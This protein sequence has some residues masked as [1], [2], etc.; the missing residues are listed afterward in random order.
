MKSLFFCILSCAFGFLGSL[1][2]WA[3]ERGLLSTLY[4]AV[5]VFFSVGMGSI[6]TFSLTG[7]N[8]KSI[9][10]DIQENLKRFAISG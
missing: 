10:K 2:N 3:I 1:G 6:V 7:V 5:C 9:S 4:T 8:I